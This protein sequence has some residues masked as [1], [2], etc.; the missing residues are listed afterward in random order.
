MKFVPTT[1]LVELWKLVKV[2]V[3]LIICLSVCLSV[4]PHGTTRL[5]L[6]GFSLNLIFEYFP[7]Y[8]EKIRFSLKSNK[9]K[10]Y[11]TWRF[12]YMYESI[13]LN[14]SW[15][16]NISDKINRENQNTYL[17]SIIFFPKIALLM[18]LCGKTLYSQWDHRW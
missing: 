2:T 9:N 12:M 6:D 8:I 14:S 5:P 18:K 16:R 11:F 10:G 4:C 7:K 3:S 15:M 17:Y 13:S 1:V